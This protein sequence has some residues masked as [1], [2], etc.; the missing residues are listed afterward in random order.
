MSDLEPDLESDH[1]VYKI[2]I[3]QI[4]CMINMTFDE[5]LSERHHIYKLSFKG[6]ISDDKQLQQESIKPISKTTTVIKGTIN[7]E[8]VFTMNTPAQL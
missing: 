5:N 3:S 6:L 2:N 7:L 4:F 1:V 8:L